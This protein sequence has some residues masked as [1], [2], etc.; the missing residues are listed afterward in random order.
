M[1]HGVPPGPMP[2]PLLLPLYMLALAKCCS[3]SSEMTIIYPQRMGGCRTSLQT[4]FLGWGSSFPG[5]SLWVVNKRAPRWPLSIPPFLQ[6][7]VF[8]C[9]A[10]GFVSCSLVRCHG[11]R[12]AVSCETE[13]Q[14]RVLQSRRLVWFFCFFKLDRTFFSFPWKQNNTDQILNDNDPKQRLIHHRAFK[15]HFDIIGFVW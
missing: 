2:V 11:Y 4:G 15:K 9:V 14:R 8:S 13:I 3:K 5:L 10:E 7:E 1:S 6:E 12:V